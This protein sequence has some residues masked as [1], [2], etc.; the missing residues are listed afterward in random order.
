MCHTFIARDRAPTS[1][2][3]WSAE[4]ATAAV[5]VENAS[6][7]AVKNSPVK[8]GGGRRGGVEDRASD[9]TVAQSPAAYD[10]RRLPPPPPPQRRRRERKRGRKRER[11]NE[12]TKERS[13]ERKKERTKE[14]TKEGTRRA[15]VAGTRAASAASASRRAARTRA[16]TCTRGRT[17]CDDDDDDDSGVAM[18]LCFSSFCDA[19]TR[20]DRGATQFNREELRW[21]PNSVVRGVRLVDQNGTYAIHD[22]RCAREDEHRDRW[23]TTMPF[24]GATM[25]QRPRGRSLPLT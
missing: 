17:W 12:R 25:T 16:M 15:A 5:Y 4:R 23:C 2:A 14:R 10:R 8:T 18:V 19:T 20:C 3:A 13:K 11:K 21:P 22:A 6:A 24:D 9:F 1:S 7:T